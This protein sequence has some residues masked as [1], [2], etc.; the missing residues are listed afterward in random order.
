MFS[1]YD[2]TLFPIVKVTIE[3]LPQDNEFDNIGVIQ[4]FLHVNL[5]LMLSL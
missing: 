4:K 2:E 5:R 3:G 1:T